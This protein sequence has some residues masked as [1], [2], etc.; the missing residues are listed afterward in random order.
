MSQEKKIYN[1]KKIEMPNIIK[2]NI[3]K[4]QYNLIFFIV[5]QISNQWQAGQVWITIY[6]EQEAND[7]GGRRPE[8][9][10]SF[11]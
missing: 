6:L 10:I 2:P 8:L 5:V 1:I 7:T 11:I 9:Q 4:D 3:K